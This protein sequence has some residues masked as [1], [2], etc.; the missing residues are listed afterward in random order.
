MQQ[1]DPDLSRLSYDMVNDGVWGFGLEDLPDGWGA[2]GVKFW[3]NP[4]KELKVTGF[5]PGESL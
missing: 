3:A 1:P 4:Q 2:A 5:L